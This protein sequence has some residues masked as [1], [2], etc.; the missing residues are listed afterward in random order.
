MTSMCKQPINRVVVLVVKYL[1]QT[2][3][4]QS[5]DYFRYLTVGNCQILIQ[6]VH[7]HNIQAATILTEILVNPTINSTLGITPLNKGM[8]KPGDQYLAS[9]IALSGILFLVFVFLGFGIF[10][11]LRNKDRR[12]SAEHTLETDT[13]TT[14]QEEIQLTV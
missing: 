14:H 8:R 6:A 7:F 4:L 5:C 10:L 2:H 11:L 13:A 1:K 9:T 3:L 12:S